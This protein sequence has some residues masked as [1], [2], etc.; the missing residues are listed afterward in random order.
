MNLYVMLNW[1]RPTQGTLQSPDQTGVIISGTWVKSNTLSLV[2]RMR[3]FVIHCVLRF[4]FQ[5]M[6]AVVKKVFYYL[7]EIL[8]KESMQLFLHVYLLLSH[9]EYKTH[10]SREVVSVQALDEV[11]DQMKPAVLH[12]HFAHDL[13]EKNEQILG[14][15]FKF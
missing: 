1:A 13:Y 8:Q 12:L 14:E 2:R 6:S 7:Y 4:L 10:K 15:N 5:S 11:K 3:R 9:L